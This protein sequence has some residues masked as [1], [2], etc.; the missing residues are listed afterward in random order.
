MRQVVRVDVGDG[1]GVLQGGRHKVCAAY[2]STARSSRVLQ[3][4]LRSLPRLKAGQ[5]VGKVVA[6][7]GG[8]V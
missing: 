2:V 4:A 3:A 6:W 5:R 8:A 1:G 7:V